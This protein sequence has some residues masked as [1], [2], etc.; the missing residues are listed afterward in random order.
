MTNLSVNIPEDERT[1][2][3]ALADLKLLLVVS[4]EM[5]VLSFDDGVSRT[6]PATWVSCVSKGIVIVESYGVE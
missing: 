1:S 6:E 2:A 3:G 4:V 5:S